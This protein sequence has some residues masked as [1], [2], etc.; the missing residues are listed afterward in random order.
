MEPGFTLESKEPPANTFLSKPRLKKKH[1]K[2][3]K[4]TQGTGLAAPVLGP[5]VMLCLGSSL[6]MLTSQS[7]S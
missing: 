2:K 6:V 4:H 3:K 5:A 7:L 1:Q